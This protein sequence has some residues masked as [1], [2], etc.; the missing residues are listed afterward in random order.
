RRRGHRDRTRDQ[1][2]D[3]A[4]TRRQHQCRE[5]FRS[6]LHFHAPP[7]DG[8]DGLTVADAFRPQLCSIVRRRPMNSSKRL[9]ALASILAL[10]AT[11]SCI[12]ASA[13]PARV[14]PP[15]AFLDAQ[16]VTFASNS[17]SNIHGWYAPGRPG[18]GAVLLLHGVGANR[19]S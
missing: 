17:G 9:A 16:T 10:A 18:A 7:A 13:T 15:P 3:R 2:E 4:G 6:G 8:S 14:G 11:T 5:P 12:L 19:T 1:P